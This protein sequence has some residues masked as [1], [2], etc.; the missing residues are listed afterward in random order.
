M[1]SSLHTIDD[2]TTIA[3]I[4]GLRI[5]DNKKYILVPESG[6]DVLV[7]IGHVPGGVRAPVGLGDFFR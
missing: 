3:V 7:P 6:L 2:I 5:D 4:S 1:A